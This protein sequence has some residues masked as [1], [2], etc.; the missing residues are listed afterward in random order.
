MFHYSSV[1]THHVITPTGKKVKETVVK[2]NGNQGIKKVSIMDEKGVHSDVIPLKKG[3]MKNIQ[4]HVFMPKLFH[5][6]IKNVMRK[7]KTSKHKSSKKGTR[8]SK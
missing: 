3:E 1:Q 7:K 2:V 8:K 4:N 6:N 5:A